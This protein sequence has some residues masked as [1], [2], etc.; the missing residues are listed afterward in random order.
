MFTSED[1]AVRMELLQGLPEYIDYLDKRVV[2]DKIY[3][4]LSTG[5]TDTEPAIREQTVK[6][7]LSVAP[8]L[9]D[10]QLNSDLLR[11]LAITQNDSQQE[12]RANT[13]ILLGKL[14]P[15]FSQNTRV[16]VLVTA[17][18]RALKDPF[19]PSRLAA[20][21]A[22]ASTA[23]YFGAQETCGKIIGTVAPALIDKDKTVRH[24][25]T[26]AMEVFMKKVNEYITSLEKEDEEDGQQGSAGQSSWGGW[27]ATIAAG[28]SS[29]LA[30][31][32][33]TGSEPPSTN[34]SRTATPSRFELKPATVNKPAV[35]KTNNDDSWSVDADSW[36]END[37]IDFG[38]DDEPVKTAPVGKPLKVTPLA[39]KRPSAFGT[40][41]FG[42]SNN[43][44]S[45][46]NNPRAVA[47][48]KIASRPV[49]ARKIPEKKPPVED[50]DG[51]GD[52]WGEI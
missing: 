31:S 50:E 3:P 14:A 23:E 7:V 36:N 5:F 37:D 16:A 28:L 29:K 41:S 49:A 34:I 44:S 25:A 2:S 26:K 15:L 32:A 13:T 33:K 39:T 20:L 42:G 9:Y 52:E 40:T 8:K 46:S 43:T 6:A 38:E 12:I 11:Q 27:T 30:A 10:R 4:A 51:W 24:E 1:K 22:L 48:R 18:G 47:P 35:P 17:F 45:T 21:M 19:V